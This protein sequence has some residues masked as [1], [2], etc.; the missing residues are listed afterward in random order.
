MCG[1]AG[2]FDLSG[3]PVRSAHL[4]EMAEKLAHRGPDDAGTFVDDNFGLSHRRLAILDLSRRAHQPMTSPDRRYTLV[5]NGCI[6]NYRELAVG[7]EQAGFSLRSRSDTEVL[8]LGCAHYGVR[9]FVPQLNGMFAFALWDARERRLCLVRDRFG[10]KPLYIFQKGSR[11]VFASEVKAFMA[12]P[13]FSV[14]VN[15]SALAEYFVFQNIFR[16]H[17]LFR[18]VD[19]LPPATIMEVDSGGIR[20]ATYWDFD[21]SRP[22]ESL[23]ERET[24]EETRRLLTVSVERQLV[25]DVPVGAYLS[26]GMDS[27]SLVACAAKHIPRLMTFTA[28]FEMSA[29]EGIESTF[30]ER[31]N[32]ELTA[33]LFQTE[34]YEQ[35]INASD[36]DW[37]MPRVIWHL[38]DIRLGMS[39]QNYYIA[40]LASKFVKV[41]LSGAGGDELF[42]GYPWRYYRAFRA[43]GPQEY[44]DAYF[45]FWQRLT[46]RDQRPEIFSSAVFDAIKEEN[47]YEIFGSVFSA[48]D[49]LKTGTAEE[50]IASSLYFE[51]KTFLHGLCV[52]GDR[53]SM[54][55]GLEE[56]FPFLDN[57]L[58]EFAQKIPVRYKLGDLHQMMTLDED[59]VRKKLLAQERFGA[60]KTVLRRAM[61]GLLPAEVTARPKAGFSAPDASWY[62]GEKAVYLRETLLDRNLASAE[63]INPDFVRRIVEEHFDHKKNHRLLI[64]SF[65][66]FEWWCRIFL[67]GERPWEEERLRLHA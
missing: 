20:K 30:D 3:E 35:V 54:A 60:G 7:L 36:I 52:V 64:W 4:E 47:P 57:E 53:L 32:A 63:F 55:S 17:T 11:L 25:S 33:Y 6:Y 16:S 22:D 62:R 59:E 56:R 42:G 15:P 19:I 61:E 9:A 1:L 10:K 27:G 49:R 23:S 66:S 37:A 26:G 24:V 48:T 50:Q 44:L 67:G 43:L 45:E 41:C 34:H 12:L 58:V 21:F 46:R 38:E 65:L 18:N 40:R 28:G 14:E 5:F 29:V 13:E 31:R 8:L 2:V 51:C 39:Y